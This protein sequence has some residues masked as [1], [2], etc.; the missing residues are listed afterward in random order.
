M[1]F[2]FASGLCL[3]NTAYK[4]LSISYIQMLKSFTPVP[5]LLASYLIGK[6][7]PSTTQLVLVIIVS[8]GVAFASIGESYFSIVGFLCQVPRC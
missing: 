3:G 4:Y 2:F 1:G 7:N 6:E 5:T 8:L